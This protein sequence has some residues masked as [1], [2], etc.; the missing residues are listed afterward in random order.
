MFRN[1]NQPV[2]QS[3]TKPSCRRESGNTP[4]TSFGWARHG[5]TAT[6]SSTLR[7]VRANISRNP[8]E[9]RKANLD[10]YMV[11]YQRHNTDADAA[12]MAGVRSNMEKLIEKKTGDVPQRLE[13]DRGRTNRPVGG[14]GTY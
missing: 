7:A 3:Q 12:Q 14:P 13:A 10:H 1:A 9:Q 11:E 8:P 2:P 4:E 6:V 5:R